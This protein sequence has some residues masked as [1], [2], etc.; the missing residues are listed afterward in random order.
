MNGAA[1]ITAMRRYLVPLLLLG[2]VGALVVLLLKMRP[3]PERPPE[4]P[5]AEKPPEPAPAETG[6]R[7]ATTRTRLDEN[8]WLRELERVLERD[9]LSNAYYFR[10]KVCEEIDDIVEN[11][12]LSR[13]LLDAIRKYGLESEDPKRRD[14][15][16][17]ILRVF[18]HPEATEMIREGFYGAKT[19]SEQM[20]FLEAMSH[21]YH[22]P[23]AA[24]V[25][26]LD[27]TLHSEDP[28][29]RTVAFRLIEEYSGDPVLI[30]DT[31]IQA[32]EGTTRRDQAD[33]M[34]RTIN[35]YARQ[36]PRAKEQIRDLLKN[37]A[38]EDLQILAGGIDLWGD[39]EDAVHLEGLAMQHPDM[40]EF[41]RERA[42][43][44]RFERR[45]E[46]G[47]TTEEDR[48]R[49]RKRMEELAEKERQK[50]EEQAPPKDE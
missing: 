23:K 26:A 30:V 3:A 31:A 16:L 29:V 43:A 21:S 24:A 11:G 46:A 48:E 13:N 4:P 15:V 47:T 12:K 36:V 1:T 5:R 41:L 39:E 10:S 6:L 44:I 28:E 40:A 25:W 32:F 2:A 42:E 33:S 34:I 35:T 45:E 37:P 18:Q 50:T 27:K 17:P 8:R 38:P 9:D 7:P 22:D 49:H 14:V 20:L 19:E